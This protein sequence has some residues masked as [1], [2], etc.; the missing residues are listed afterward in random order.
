MNG[1][2]I[3][4][5]WKEAMFP[6]LFMVSSFCHLGFEYSFFA[7]VDTVGGCVLPASSALCSLLM[8]CSSKMF[9]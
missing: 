7:D 8:F 3:G 6:A 5:L 1:L 4:L 9:M 2:L